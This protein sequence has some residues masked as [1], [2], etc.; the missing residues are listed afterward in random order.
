MVSQKNYFTAAVYMVLIISF[1]VSSCQNEEPS[2]L[3]AESII[4]APVSVT[5]TG[6]YFTINKNTKIYVDSDTGVLNSTANYIAGILRA[7]TGFEIPVKYRA[8]KPRKGSICLEITRDGAVQCDESYILNIDRKMLKLSASSPE[9]V[10]RGIQTIRQLLP[11]KA[12]SGLPADGPWKIATGIITDKPLYSYRGL[13]L[14][15]SRHFFR[16]EDV[17][18]VI[19]MISLYKINMLHLHLSDDQGWRIEINSWPDLTKTGGSTQVGGGEGGFY[20]QDQYSD[21]VEYAGERFITVVPEIDMPGHTNAALAS[22]PELNCD[23]KAKE[24]Y[25]GTRVGFSSL[26]V[27]KEVTYKFVND[28]VREISALTPGPY[29]HIGGDESFSTKKKDYRIFIERVQK[30]VNSHGKTVI[31]WDE[32]ATTTLSGGSVSQYWRNPKNARLAVEQGGKVLFS[33]ANRAYLDMKYD[34]TTRLGLKWAGYIE[35]DKAYSWDPDTLIDGITGEIILGVEA[36]LWTETVTTPDEI[37]FM[38]FPRIIC[39][40]EIGWT[41]AS[42]RDWIEFRERLSK[43][44]ERL[45]TM[46]I[47]YF[48][49]KVVPFR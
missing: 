35:A 26:C 43:H 41:Q 12:E 7:S 49:S 29:F 25:T 17:K 38:I 31:G 15:V 4:P 18:R 2:D 46:R 44:G 21:I 30:I 10:F 6:R 24:L 11:A 1:S 23:E 33:P 13:M 45:D 20:T 28:V 39:I 14:D 42:K 3:A 5:A 27:E 34:S 32:I 22:Y 37:E 19:D 48:R 40:A 8:A 47:N 16:V 36:P 9:G